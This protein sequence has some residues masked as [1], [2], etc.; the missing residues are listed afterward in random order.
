MIRNVL[1]MALLL[2][3][4]AAEL[5]VH[6]AF[7]YPEGAVTGR[8][9]GL[10]WS[11]AWTRD[12]ESCAVVE[13]SLGYTDGAANALRVS[14]SR[15]DTAGPATT[16]SFRGVAGG[17]LSDAW[18]S[19]LYR[20]PSSNSL[21]EGVNFY[22]GTTPVFAVSNPS[23]T[24]GP[25]ITLNDFVSGGG[26][27]TGTGSFGA[28]HFIVLHLSDGGGPGGEDQV[29]LFIDPPLTG[30]VAAPDGVILGAGLEFDRLRVAGQSGA[31]LEV[32]ELRIGETFLDVAP[33]L[34][35]DNDRDGLTNK[36]E[37][38]L[39]LDPNRSD[40]DLILAIRAHAEFF[41]LLDDE[42]LRA[43]AGNGALV[44]GDGGGADLIL[45]LQRTVDLSAWA[46][47]ETIRRRVALL[48]GKRFLRLKIEGPPSPGSADSLPSPP[49][50]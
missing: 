8:G 44:E 29:E 5:L 2:P 11:E 18:I 20:L 27:A 32:D 33:F 40:A 45:Q 10:G 7:D 34:S 37:T 43:L 31:S 38:E 50:R 16:R 36:Q 17:P 47:D 21:Y 22:L 35:T 19:F 13:G 15:L 4:C 49:I 41:G 12:G 9:G 48:P 26:V 39:G 1:L 24:P 25:G 23:T 3:P 46:L 14:G 6:D 42:G 30:P 28:T